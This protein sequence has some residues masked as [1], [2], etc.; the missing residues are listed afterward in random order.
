MNF[1]EEFINSYN[2]YKKCKTY[3][4]RDSIVILPALTVRTNSKRVENMLYILF[5]VYFPNCALKKDCDV[6]LFGVPGAVRAHNKE[7]LL[8]VYSVN[9]LLIP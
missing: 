1:K 3:G 2:Y 9:S 5:F 7:K 6:V 4:F 8:C